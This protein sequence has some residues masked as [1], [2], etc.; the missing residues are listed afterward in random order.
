[1]S[2]KIITA[3]IRTPDKSANRLR[4]Q[5]FVPG[6]MYGQEDQSTP[7][8]IE[9]KSLKR[10]LREAG[11]NV[12]FEIA[13]ENEV[14]PVRLQEIQ[15]DPVTK[16]IVHIDAQVIN[17]NQKI[18]AKVPIRLEG[19]YDIEKRGI[20]L[21]RQKDSI[22]VEGLPQHIPSHINVL[23]Q[24]LAQ[25]D[26]IRVADIEIS[27]ELSI[28]DDTEEIVLSAVKNSRIDL[29]PGNIVEEYTT[30]KSDKNEDENLEESQ[31]QDNNE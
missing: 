27:E 13:M 21:Q 4:R 3:N 22:E 12:F 8:M 29:E 6:V 15:R 28:L 24:G 11:Q 20:A 26:A 9:S 18:K 17:R 23:V 25:G 7:I 10:L 19:T 2:D 30:T 5:G 14:K 16:E 1:M 31:G